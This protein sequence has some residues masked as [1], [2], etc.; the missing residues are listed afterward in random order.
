MSFNIK[1][2]SVQVRLSSEE[3]VRWLKFHKN[4]IFIRIPCFDCLIFIYLKKFKLKIAIS[5]SHVSPS[6]RIIYYDFLIYER[7]LYDLI[8]FYIFVFLLHLLISI[9]GGYSNHHY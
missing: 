7:A 5:R 4:D 6:G 8:I 2:V 9:P 1:K 3:N